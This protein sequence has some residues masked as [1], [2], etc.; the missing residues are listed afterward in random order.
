M[1]PHYPQK[2]PIPKNTYACNYP[3]CYCDGDC[4][5][6]LSN[7]LESLSAQEKQDIENE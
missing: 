1:L 7:I 3:Y 4:Q 6:V 2:V 5:E